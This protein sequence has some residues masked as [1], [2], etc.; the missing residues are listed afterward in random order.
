MI[1]EHNVVEYI[2]AHAE[3]DA[4]I[5]AC[6]Y[7]LGVQG[8]ITRCY[9]MTN[10]EGREDHFSFVPQEQFAAYLSAREEGFEIIGAYHSHPVTPARPSKE[11]IR[12]LIDPKLI[13]II[14]SLADGIKTIKAFSIRE[15]KALE[16]PLMITEIRYE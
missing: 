4:P 16:E 3:Q 7:L 2:F 14:V 6:G 12:L 5:E 9:P 11:D 15:G 10:A 8:R 13:Y 1:I